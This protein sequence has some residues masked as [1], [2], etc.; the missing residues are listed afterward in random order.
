MSVFITVAAPVPS[1]RLCA[2][3]VSKISVGKK[4]SVQ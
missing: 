3:H 1:D 4:K 2:K